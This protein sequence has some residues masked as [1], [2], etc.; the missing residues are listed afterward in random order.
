MDAGGQGIEPFSTIF[1]GALIGSWIGTE[2]ANTQTIQDAGFL[3][4]SLIYYGTV[5]TTMFSY[6]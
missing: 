3:G 6:I 5:P 1:P 4:Q 2:V